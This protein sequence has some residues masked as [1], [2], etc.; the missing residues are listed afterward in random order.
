MIIIAVLS[1][2]TYSLIGCRNTIA[3][4]CIIYRKFDGKLTEPDAENK[5]I[6]LL[7]VPNGIP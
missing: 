4:D 2:P 6:F 3:S 7:Q 1:I 5:Y